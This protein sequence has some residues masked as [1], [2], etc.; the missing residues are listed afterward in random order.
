MGNAVDVN[1]AVNLV[2]DGCEPMQ[3]ASS[4]D[5]WNIISSILHTWHT[6]NDSH[7]QISNMI[8]RQL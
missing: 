3:A 8:I 7:L 2:R 5:V 6:M 1:D 4:A